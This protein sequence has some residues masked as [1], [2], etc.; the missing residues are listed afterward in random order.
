VCLQHVTNKF[1]GLS[2]TD[3]SIVITQKYIMQ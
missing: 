3:S 2:Y 1:Q